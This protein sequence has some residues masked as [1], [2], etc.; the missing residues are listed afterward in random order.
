METSI[1][2]LLENLINEPFSEEDFKHNFNVWN[3]AEE[4]HKQEIID[5]VTFGQNNHTVMISADLE[6]AEQYYAETYGK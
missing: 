4:M 1:E 3:K 6:K 5:A 2:W